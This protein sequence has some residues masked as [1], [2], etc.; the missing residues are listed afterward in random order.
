MSKSTVTCATPADAIKLLAA[1]VKHSTKIYSTSAPGGLPAMDPA[2]PVKVTVHGT[3]RGVVD[4]VI[5]ASG[6]RLV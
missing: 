1:C 4:D 5:R 6:A 3:M 2:T